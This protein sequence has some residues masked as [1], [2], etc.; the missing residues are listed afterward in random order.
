MKVFWNNHEFESHL[1][2]VSWKDIPG[3]YI[4]AGLDQ[5]NR[6]VPLYIGQASS[7]SD[8]LSGHER[9]AEAVR[10]GATHIHAKVV[11]VQRER[12]IIEQQL[13]STFQPPLNVLLK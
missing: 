13:I 7:L 4:F 9:W 6:W 10:R 3:I 5:L 1:P 2:S 12:D 8:R 11:N